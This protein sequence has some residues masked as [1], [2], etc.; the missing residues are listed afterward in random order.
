MMGDMKNK[1][2]NVQEEIEGLKR[3]KEIESLIKKGDIEN[4]FVSNVSKDSETVNNIMADDILNRIGSEKIDTKDVDS[5]VSMTASSSKISVRKTS[6]KQQKVKAHDNKREAKKL[7]HPVNAYSK[8]E[9][10]KAV[11]RSI[12][13]VQH[14]VSGKA[15]PRKRR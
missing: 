3:L 2:K 12:K 4:A 5:I 14:G 8:K 7:Q 9:G 15:K 1:K 13:K 6:A 11:S 10:K